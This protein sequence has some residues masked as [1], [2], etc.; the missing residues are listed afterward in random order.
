MLQVQSQ[1]YNGLYSLFDCKRVC[2]IEGHLFAVQQ[3]PLIKKYMMYQLFG[4]L[5]E[6]CVRESD[7]EILIEERRN[8]KQKQKGETASVNLESGR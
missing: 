1:G 8:R 6:H 5:S 3:H 7:K 4:I 2:I